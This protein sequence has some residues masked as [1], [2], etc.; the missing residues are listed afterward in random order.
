MNLTLKG[1]VSRNVLPGRVLGEKRALRQGGRQLLGEKG[2]VQKRLRE[3]VWLSVSK[4]LWEGFCV[5]NQLQ[6]HKEPQL[7]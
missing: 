6:D 3:R 5:I 2:P 4:S 1:K 7:W